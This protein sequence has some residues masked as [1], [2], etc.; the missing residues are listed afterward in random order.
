LDKIFHNKNEAKKNKDEII[1]NNIS[2]RKENEKIELNKEVE[3]NE[4]NTNI[5]TEQNIEKRNDENIKS[6][7]PNSDLINEYNNQNQK[8]H[9]ITSHTHSTKTSSIDPAINNQKNISQRGNSYNKTSMNANQE[10]LSYQKKIQ[11]IKK[12]LDELAQKT[13]KNDRNKKK[14]KSHYCN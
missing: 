11:E 1:H 5:K 2:A 13:F 10:L 14:S 8:D 6:E 12:S 4:I 9:H 3:K 7:K